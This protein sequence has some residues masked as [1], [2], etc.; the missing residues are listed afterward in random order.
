M[1]AVLHPAT[2]AM[3]DVQQI[4]A[5]GG[6]LYVVT[7]NALYQKEGQRGGWRRVLSPAR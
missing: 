7:R 2:R 6:T 3:S 1:Q 5:E 4:F